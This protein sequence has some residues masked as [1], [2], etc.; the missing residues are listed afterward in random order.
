MGERKTKKDATLELYQDRNNLLKK[1]RIIFCCCCLSLLFLIIIFLVYYFINQYKSIRA[2]TITGFGESFEITDGLFVNTNG[3]IYFNLGNIE[4]TNDLKIEYLELYYIE[5]N[6]KKVICGVNDNVLS[7]VDYKGYEEYFETSKIK[8][9]INNLYLDIKYNNEVEKIKLTLLEDYVNDD[10]LFIN[11]K[12]ITKNYKSQINEDRAN[13]LI[14]I[15]KN[16]FKK[17]ESNYTYEINDKNKKIQF[18]Y[19]IENSLLIV[20]ILNNNK[21]CEEY[22]FDL[23]YLTLSFDSEN[24]NFSTSFHEENQDEKQLIKIDEFINII[25]NI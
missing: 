13:E 8:F 5:N 22:Y 2:Y 11:D 18:N 16:K 1:I 17:T 23:N 14:T 10:F 4:N 7:F 3:K 6:V 21:I 9:I 19:L 24:Y 12:K 15:I 25:S 20:T